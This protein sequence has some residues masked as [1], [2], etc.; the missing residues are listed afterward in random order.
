MPSD[1]AA[2]TINF[3]FL[4]HQDPDEFALDHPLDMLHCCLHYF[5]MAQRGGDCLVDI[6]EREN[7]IDPPSHIHC[8]LQRFVEQPDMACYKRGVR[9][10][11][12]GDGYLVG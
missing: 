3:P 5:F 12:S 1:L 8:H 11:H 4:F 6:I 7:D 9:N 2:R 10:E